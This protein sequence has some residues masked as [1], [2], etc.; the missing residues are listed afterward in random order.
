MDWKRKQELKK[1]AKK[2]ESKAKYWKERLYQK[3][4]FSG[5]VKPAEI[6]ALRDKVVDRYK[7]ARRIYG[8][9]NNESKQNEIHNYILKLRKSSSSPKLRQSGLERHF[10]FAYLAITS[11]VTAL[12][13]ISFNLTGY[14]VL[15]QV[16]NNLGF[17][18]VA[19]FI[20]GLVFVFF[21]FKNKK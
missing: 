19:F 6:N 20:L 13:F 16:K 10:G 11:F 2:A 7:E 1:N 17:F 14:V 12:F 5:Y 18:S 3:E 4:R 9:L 8:T 21:Y 15:G